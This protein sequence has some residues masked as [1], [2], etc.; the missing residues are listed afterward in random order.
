MGGAALKQLRGAQDA[1]G[2]AD[3]QRIAEFSE[4]VCFAFFGEPGLRVRGVAAV[5]TIGRFQ[6]LG[7]DGRGGFQAFGAR[8]KSGGA[9]PSAENSRAG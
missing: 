7:V 3:R 6:G 9:T 4:R 8:P 1:D 2:S 5:L